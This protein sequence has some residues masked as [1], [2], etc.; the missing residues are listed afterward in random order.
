MMK[1]HAAMMAERQ[2]MMADMK[3]VDQKLNE[4]VARMKSAQG[5]TK[6]DAIA[7]V[8]QELVAQH[9]RMRDRMMT[10]QGGM[11]DGMMSMMS[12]MQNAPRK[13]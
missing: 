5:E 2:K 6:V 13:N 8:V 4:L 3:A 12:T 7:A 1:T 9:T 11:M 10:M